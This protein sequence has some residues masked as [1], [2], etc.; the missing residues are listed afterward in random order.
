MS[1]RHHHGNPRSCDMRFSRGNVEFFDPMKG[2]GFIAEGDHMDVFFTTNAYLEE[3]M[4]VTFLRVERE[5][6]PCALSV[7]PLM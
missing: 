5:G 2:E 4:R 1:L 7:I 6:G 3:G